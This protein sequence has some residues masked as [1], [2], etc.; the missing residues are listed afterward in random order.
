M[1][2]LALSA[3]GSALGN[4]LLPEGIS[5][6][7]SQI[8]GAAIG[9][10]VGATMGAYIDSML[11]GGVG[12]SR[13]PRL[14]DLQV[15][16]SSEG[17][18]IPR[19]YGRA[20]VAG[21]V[22]WATNYLETSTTTRS[23]GKGG[24]GASATT[25]SYSVSFA[26]GLCEGEITRIG[27]IWADGKLLDLSGLTWRLYKGE[28]TQAPDP[29]IEAVEGEGEAPAYRG[30]AYIVFENLPVTP[31]GNRLP[32]LSVEVFRSFSDVESRVKAVNVIPGAGEFVYGTEVTREYLSETSSRPLNM[33]NS[34]GVADFTLAMDQLEATCPQV[35]A[36]ALVVSW[37]GNDLRSEHCTITPRVET[38]LKYTGPATWQVA[39]VTRDV[40]QAVSQVDGRPSYGGTPSDA[41]VVA[42]LKDMKARGL[43]CTFYPFVMM[44]IAPGNALPDPWSGTASQ[45]AYPW[46]GRIKGSATGIAAFFGTAVPEDFTL[47]GESVTYAGPHEWSYRRMVLHDAYLCL[48]AGGVEAFLIGSELKGLTQYRDGAG[49]FP[50]V[51]ALQ[52]LAADLR[53]VLGPDVKISYAADWS[54]YG[55]YQPDDGSGDLCFPLDPLWGD[56]NIDFVGIDNYLP[57]TD[58]RE[59]TTHL[60]RLAGTSAIYDLAYLRDGITGGENYDWY[61]ASQSDRDAQIRSPISDGAYG[62]P[63]VYRAK[64]FRSWWDNAHVE[65]AGGVELGEPT[66]WVAQGKP[67]WFTELGC[68]AI[69]KGTNAP[70]LF[71]DPKSAE[72]ALPPYST[73]ARD[74]YLQRCFIEAQ[75]DVW[76]P[77]SAHFDAAKNPVSIVYGGRMVEASRLFYWTW[78]A[79]PYPAFP[80]DADAWADAAQWAY[81]HWLNGRLGA[82][83]LGEL[84]SAIMADVG[85]TRGETRD[86]T[87]IVDGYVIDRIMSPRDALAPLMLARFFDGCESEGL[88]RFTHLGQASVMMLAADDLAV[89]DDSAQAGYRLTRGQESEYPCSVK[90]SYFEGDADY[91]QATIESRRLAVNSE[92]V[93]TTTLA[94]V[95]H[96]ADAQA[97]ADIWLQQKWVERER[98]TL[99]LPPSRLALDPGDVVT[100]D[101]GHRQVDLRLTG[102]SDEDR[103]AADAVA[104]EASVFGAVARVTR[105]AQT[106][107][108]TSPGPVLGLF[109]DLPLIAGSETPYAPRL[110]VAAEPWPGEVALY[111]EA[112]D[113]LSL[114]RTLDRMATIGRTVTAL[115]AGP[116]SRWDEGNRLEVQ[117]VSGALSSASAAAVLAGANVAALETAEG[118][119]EVIQF[120]E[121]VLTESGNYELGGLLRG[122]AGSE[123]AMRDLLPGEAR[124]V[125]IDGALAEIGLQESERGLTREWRWGP[126]TLG[127]DDATYQSVT[128][129]FDGIGLKPLSPVHLRG[130][131][132]ASGDIALSWV[133]RTRVNGDSWAGSEVPLGEEEEAYEIEIREGDTVKRV[134][135]SATPTVVYDA[136][137]QIADFG[138]DDFTTFDITA[139]QI[140]RSFGRGT[141]RSMTIHV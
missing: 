52:A 104:S 91:R 95:T 47:N 111:R 133:R 141:G 78:D 69:D 64:D 126:A 50:A 37:F 85:F 2:T 24:G 1:A 8:T 102:L 29:L 99:T 46:R 57:V 7:G 22:I 42:A 128:R 54:E 67:I 60:D 87:G 137:A 72:S 36:A 112:G 12:S 21:Q 94:M 86:L 98:A 124:F 10:A 131:R 80:A 75:S 41:S 4:T 115:A 130:R 81:G 49:D 16:T 53:D 88:I 44:D 123:G 66:D 109:L 18:A 113:G 76:D 138:S 59:G 118:E 34:E 71:L 122:Q 11:F 26:L 89:A 63:W 6:L 20:R 79:R 5:I 77:A 13:G 30:L 61:Y 114:D 108:T 43:A 119:W 73:G 120:R 134:L 62:K 23:G 125:L 14:S 140:S 70:N 127:F 129:A 55:S 101:L 106:Q 68:P 9:Q 31:F 117:L 19:L 121:A 25:Y 17:A 15:M 28:V 58:W 48:A 74:D 97:M 65:R 45:P 35:N 3:V 27:R 51:A 82:A 83:P 96:Q 38:T 116:T 110:A 135:N 103:R 40:A 105:A 39:G 90:I 100:L 107:A 136:A 33:H 84:V 132:D 32:Q 139:F 56:D 93:A 92:R